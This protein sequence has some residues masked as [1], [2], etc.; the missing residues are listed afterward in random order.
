LMSLTCTFR[1][2]HSL[3]ALGKPSRRKQLPRL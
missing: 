3:M 2:D 1:R